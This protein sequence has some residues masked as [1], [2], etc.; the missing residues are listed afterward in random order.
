MGFLDFR[1]WYLKTIEHLEKNYKNT[2]NLMFFIGFPMSF[3]DFGSG[4]FQNH[5]QSMKP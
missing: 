4:S 2:E 5:G 3:M 1:L